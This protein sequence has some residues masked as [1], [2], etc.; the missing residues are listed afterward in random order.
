MIRFLLYS[1][2]FFT[3][4]FVIAEENKCTIAEPDAGQRRLCFFALNGPQE[5]ER[6]EQIKADLNC[7]QPSDGS[8][9]K[10]D[11]DEIEAAGT[12]VDLEI[13]EFYA[14][15]EDS[16][17]VSKAFEE[18][19]NT[20]CD[21]L[22]ISG[23]HVGYYTGKRA[24]QT[25]D[26][27]GNRDASHVDL[28][29]KFLENLSCLQDGENSDCRK[30]FSNI[31]YV[32]L[33]GSHTSGDKVLE[34]EGKSGV[35]DLALSRMENKNY[36]QGWT[37]ASAQYLNREY[38]STV[39]ENNSLSSRYLKM[40]P[41]A[42]IYSWATAERISEG[43]PE[44]FAEHLK[45]ITAHANIAG[46]AESSQ[47][48]ESKVLEHV[49]DI[50]STTAEPE[51]K[52][53]KLTI[54]DHSGTTI[55]AISES[56]KEKENN[57]RK[58]GCDLSE[59]IESG[60]QEAITKA[61]DDVL[62][63]GALNQN[64]NRIF[65]AL[66]YDSPL[67]AEVQEAIREKLRAS[68]PFQRALAEQADNNKI[69]VVKR[70][71]ALY[72]YKQIYSEDDQFGNLENK[73]IGDLIS[74]YDQHQNRTDAIGTAMKEMIAELIW[75]NNLGSS[76]AS[77]TNIQTLIDRFGGESND[78]HLRQYA[79]LMKIPSGLYTAEDGNK[80]KDMFNTL[81][82]LE[83]S[84]EQERE[85][86]SFVKVW[87]HL[88]M[89]NGKDLTPI[90]EMYD[91]YNEAFKNE[92]DPAKKEKLSKK[93]TDIVAGV[94]DSFAVKKEDCVSNESGFPLSE[95]TF[96]VTTSDRN[97]MKKVWEEACRKR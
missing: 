35:D 62:T 50:L 6:V 55:N 96:K 91:S 78:A 31:R 28:N 37:R 87:A 49:L 8:K 79:E 76:P 81:F 15:A 85:S 53:V 83:S 3:L 64:L 89:Q 97:W 22:V 34:H 27:R 11:S 40:F 44:T 30:W 17:S 14:N 10:C 66:N 84:E 82:E 86:W 5:S 19:T 38:A 32:H 57:N 39:D 71:D 74:L 70:A 12:A 23:H 29:L 51:P 95:D 93:V 24:D 67:S 75:K 65:Y 92:S 26:A 9:I 48:D 13:K 73:F 68:E 1:L 63:A 69:G 77:Q 18:M 2:C 43:S 47:P 90:Q 41:S 56:D 46:Q 58:I 16:P 20:R 52:C 61:L 94:G 72:L 25:T 60:D 33:H 45:F 59:A 88:Q 42:Q 54:G 4:N 7:I 80:V 36:P 21:G